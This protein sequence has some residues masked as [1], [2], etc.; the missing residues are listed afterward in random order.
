MSSVAKGFKCFVEPPVPVRARRERA[1]PGDGEGCVAAG[2][3]DKLKLVET[4]CVRFPISGSP[5]NFDSPFSAFVNMFSAILLQ[6][7]VFESF[8]S[9]IIEHNKGR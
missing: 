3:V 7:L 4:F 1:F 6:K 5:L 8:W 2:D 9:N